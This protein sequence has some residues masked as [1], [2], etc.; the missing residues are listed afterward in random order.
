MITFEEFFEKHCIEDIEFL[1]EHI[2][3][4]KLVYQRGIE[5][6]SNAYD[7]TYLKNNQYDGF[8]WVETV[9]GHE[10]WNS[11]MS[12]ENIDIFYERYPKIDLNKVD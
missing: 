4:A 6:K 12:N 10:F 5:C 11:I 1:Q 2:E 8:E 3:I 9:E 7:L